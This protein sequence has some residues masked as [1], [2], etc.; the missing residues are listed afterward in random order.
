MQTTTHLLSVD[1]EP[2][3]IKK[4]EAFILARSP[5]FAALGYDQDLVTE[6]VLDSLQFV[7]LIYYIQEFSAVEID[8]QSLVVDQFRTLALIEQNF[9]GGARPNP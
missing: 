7:E 1:D 6:G 9:L 8:F 5:R 4:I 3:P 2:P